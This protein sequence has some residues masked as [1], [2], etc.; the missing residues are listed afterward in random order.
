MIDASPLPKIMQVKTEP[1]LTAVTLGIVLQLIFYLTYLLTLYSVLVGSLP[2]DVLAP[3][4]TNLL[5]MLS[6]VMMI[7]SGVGSGFLYVLL[8]ARRE[9]VGAIAARGGATTGAI[10]FATSMIIAGILAVI[11]VLP[12]IGNQALTTATSQELAS[13]DVTTRMLGLGAAGIIGGTIVLSLITAV[14]GAMLGG[15]GGGL[16][17]VFV[18]SRQSI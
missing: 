4:F 1:L 7:G 18:Q 16:G 12:L 15:L 3:R 14:L 10:I 11:I 2:A 13:G 17:G 9:P 5:T 8:H 6:C